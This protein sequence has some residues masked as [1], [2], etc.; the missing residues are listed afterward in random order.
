[1]IMPGCEQKPF[2]F[3]EWKSA[4]GSSSEMGEFLINS[5]KFNEISEHK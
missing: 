1:M 3:K 5:Q 4:Q 2:G